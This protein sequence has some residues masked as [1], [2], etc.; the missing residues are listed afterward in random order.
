MSVKDHYDNLLADH[1]SWM[2]GGLD[3]NV[4]R[5]TEFF[6]THLITPLGSGLAVDLGAGSGFQSIPLAQSG[7]NVTAIDFSE[8]LV[9]ELRRNSKEFAIAIKRGDL[10]RFTEELHD[11]VELIVCMGD[12]LTHLKSIEDVTRLFRDVHSVLETEGR[13]VLSFR[14]MSAELTGLDRFFPVRMDPDRLFTCFLEYDQDHVRV[15]DLIHA[16][17]E[18]TWELKKSVYIKLRLSKDWVEDRLSGVG[19][20]IVYSDLLNGMVTL[21]II[22]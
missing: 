4:A 16:R 10:T 18:N 6:K 19:F 21:I 1:Y 22:K 5:Y 9:E 15:H 12:T 14:D 13:F 8:K 7:F 17:T 3:E 2:L 20:K 11:K